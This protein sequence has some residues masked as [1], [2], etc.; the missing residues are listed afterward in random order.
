MDFLDGLTL[1]INNHFSWLTGTNTIVKDSGGV[2][3]WSAEFDLDKAG[4][5]LF[6]SAGESLRFTI[7][8]DLTG[9][10]EFYAIIAGLAT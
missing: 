2:D 9:L 6:L 5:E 1:K 8:D 4:R 7:Q 10:D 3:V